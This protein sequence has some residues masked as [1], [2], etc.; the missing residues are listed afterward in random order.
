MFVTCQPFLQLPSKNHICLYLWCTRTQLNSKFWLYNFINCTELFEN[1]WAWLRI[2]VAENA[3]SDLASIFRLDRPNNLPSLPFYRFFI[4][5]WN[6]YRFWS[7]CSV[8]VSAW[9]GP[10]PLPER[11]P[12]L[13]RTRIW[14]IKITAEVPTVWSPIIY[15]T[16]IYCVPIYFNKRLIASNQHF[17][18]QTITAIKYLYT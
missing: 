1:N 10:V 14:K 9:R 13:P 7:P 16:C 12:Q 5:C 4:L 18:L 2:K 8:R 3:F 6:A 17:F 15:R 11:A